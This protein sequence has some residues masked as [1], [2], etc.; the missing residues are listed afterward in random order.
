MGRCSLTHDRRGKVP[1][2]RKHKDPRSKPAAGARGGRRDGGHGTGSGDVLHVGSSS[3]L[4]QGTGTPESSPWAGRPAARP[5]LSQDERRGGLTGDSAWATHTQ[6]SWGRSRATEDR[7]AEGL[8]L[9]GEGKEGTRT[10]S[11]SMSAGRRRGPFPETGGRTG[12]PS[13]GV[14]AVPGC[15]GVTPEERPGGLDTGWG[16]EN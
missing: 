5:S 14:R 2:P 12:P 11:P 6:T 7:I 13:V 10:R 9:E 1:K 3:A 4:T 15:S 16:A 8:K